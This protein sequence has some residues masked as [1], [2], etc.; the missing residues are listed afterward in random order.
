MQPAASVA[1]E[2]RSQAICRYLSPIT[3]CSKLWRRVQST[4]ELWVGAQS[5]ALFGIRE[6]SHQIARVRSGTCGVTV[7]LEAMAQATVAGAAQGL[8]TG[9]GLGVGRARRWCNTGLRAGIPND[10]EAVRW[11][12]WS[13]SDGQSTGC[14]YSSAAGKCNGWLTNWL[15]VIG[16]WLLARRSLLPM[17]INQLKSGLQR[18][19]A[20]LQL[21]AALCQMHL[22]LVFA[23]V[24]SRLHTA[25]TCRLG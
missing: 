9:G 5:G 4:G 24:A 12:L 6:D 11:Q 13:D 21:V 14:G 7:I 16:W 22:E 3:A 15:V 18:S 10:G 25:A 23:G 1:V 8:Y 17:R 20:L 2:G 19:I